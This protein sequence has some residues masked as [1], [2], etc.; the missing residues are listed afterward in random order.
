MTTG[1]HLPIRVSHIVGDSRVPGLP[2]PGGALTLAQGLR[3]NIRSLTSAAKL[4]DIFGLRDTEYHH[5]PGAQVHG[6]GGWSNG[7][8]AVRTETF[9]ADYHL[10]LG[11]L[12]KTCYN[13]DNLGKKCMFPK[14]VMEKM[15]Q[16][17]IGWPINYLKCQS[18]CQDGKSH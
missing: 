3:S 8:A 18:I 17:V 2:R 1:S 5:G 16:S 11:N 9:L 13:A 10:M 4:L 14:R 15:S 6:L 12:W 7:R